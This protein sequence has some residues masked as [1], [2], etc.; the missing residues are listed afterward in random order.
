MDFLTL[1]VTVQGETQH[2]HVLSW[3]S[4]QRTNLWSSFLQNQILRQTA[5]DTL[6]VQVYL[7]LRGQVQSGTVHSFSPIHR[8]WLWNPY[9]N[10]HPFLSH[11]EAISYWRSLNYF[12]GTWPMKSFF[13][14]YKVW[15]VTVASTYCFF[16]IRSCKEKKSRRK[17][18]FQCCVKTGQSII[19]HSA[20]TSY[21]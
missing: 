14:E 19:G 5:A 21:A 17:I 4:Y 2:F 1:E 15:Q 20:Y 18:L 11:C 7:Q 13:I 3:L 10:L 6:S 8:L 12:V 9:R 16:S